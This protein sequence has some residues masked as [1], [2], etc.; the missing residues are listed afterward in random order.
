[1]T[2]IH[3]SWRAT[4][5]RRSLAIAGL[6]ALANLGVAIVPVQAQQGLFLYVPTGSNLSAFTTSADGTLTA[7]ATVAS[8]GVQVAMRG[9]QAFAYVASSS[10]IVVVNTATQAI[11]QSL[12]L[13]HI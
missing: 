11:V 9:D 10:G 12:S 2:R 5:A 4:V 8:V 13:I 6:S 7:A 1:M 3:S